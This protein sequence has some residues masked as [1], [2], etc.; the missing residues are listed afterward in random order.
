MENAPVNSALSS[1]QQLRTKPDTPPL[2]ITAL[3]QLVL[4]IRVTLEKNG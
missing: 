1:R 2:C 4:L 3:H